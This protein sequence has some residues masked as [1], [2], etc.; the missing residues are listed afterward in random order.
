MKKH[1]SFIKTELVPSK[2]ELE[3]LQVLWS[4]GPSTVRFVHNELNHKKK[5]IQYTS[6]LKIMQIMIEKG[7]AVRDESLMKHVYKASVEEKMTK[8]LLL[9]RFMELMYNGSASRLVM[10]LLDSKNTS[11]ED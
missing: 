8:D 1:Y 3:I 11:K 7:L 9:D 2:T 4:N 6:T 5:E 10:Q